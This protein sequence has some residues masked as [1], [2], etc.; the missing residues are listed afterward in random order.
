MNYD[1]LFADA[2]FVVGVVI[3]C[4]CVRS[5]TPQTG[6]GFHAVSLSPGASSQF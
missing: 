5:P 4:V 1:C 2:D 3:T 6:E